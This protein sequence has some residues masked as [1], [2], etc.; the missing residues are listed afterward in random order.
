MLALTYN[1]LEKLNYEIPN[2]SK[3]RGVSVS[4][5]KDNDGNNTKVTYY[6]SENGVNKE[7]FLEC[8]IDDA[9]FGTWATTFMSIPVAIKAGLISGQ[10]NSSLAILDSLYHQAN[11]KPL[12][13]A[14]LNENKLTKVLEKV[15]VRANKTSINYN[16]VYATKLINEVINHFY[17]LPSSEASLKA[18]INYR[19][20]VSNSTLFPI[21][22]TYFFDFCTNSWVHKNL[23]VVN[24]TIRGG[25]AEVSDD[26]EFLLKFNLVPVRGNY[27][28]FAINNETEIVYNNRIYL[29]TDLDLIACHDC[30]T[31]SQRHDIDEYGCPSCRDSKSK[32][33]TYSTKVPELLKFKASKVNPK[34][35]YLGV[36]LEYEASS[37]RTQDAMFANKVLKDHAILK[38]DGSIHSGF[39]IVTCPAT[40][41]IH[42]EEFKSFFKDLKT[43]SGLY[44]DTNTGMHVHIS[45]K[46]LSVLTVGKMTAFLNLKDN[47]RFI[48]AIAGRTLNSYCK[49]DDRTV[50]YPLVVGAGARYNALNL[51]NRDTVEIRI[52]STPETYEEFSYKLE[53]AEA[54]TKYCSPCSVGLNVNEQ[55]KYSNFVYW[56]HKNKKFYPN[57][58]TKLKS[59]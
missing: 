22:Y 29:K 36:E 54:L 24:F 18:L 9:T 46:D 5:F 11:T 49:Q 15:F 19:K 32:I 45:R 37:S 41:D 13:L 33:H 7:E 23:R 16:N 48:E 44:Q 42:L 39:E 25:H 47:L 4:T 20:V 58:A 31:M 59:I 50:S 1:K 51:N 2:A 21:T 56:V 6:Y 35:L 17:T 14:S 53:F 55:T 34:P 28:T 38:S 57:L 10:T 43:K 40:L 27:N 30:G 52:F 12:N 3:V 26:V 8:A